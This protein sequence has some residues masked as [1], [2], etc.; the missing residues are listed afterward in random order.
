MR[1]VDSMGDASP[2]PT[3]NQATMRS[4]SPRLRFFPPLPLF[5]G[6]DAVCGAP[7]LLGR[8]EREE[9][10]R[11]RERDSLLRRKGRSKRVLCVCDAAAFFLS[12][13]F[14]VFFF[15]PVLQPLSLSLSLSL[16]FSLSPLRNPLWARPRR[17]R[18]YPVAKLKRNY[19]F[20]FLFAFYS[21]FLCLSHAL[22]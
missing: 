20:S 4:L 19:D 15:T 5:F 3:K 6:M 21:L 17:P 9:R 1:N 18:G 7:A 2:S 11:E 14:V 22:Y 8:D 13:F 16:R 12:F 10:K